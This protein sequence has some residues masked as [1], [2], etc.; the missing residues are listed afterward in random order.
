MGERTGGVWR[1]RRGPGVP[2]DDEAEPGS[3]RRSG[4]AGA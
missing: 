1:G 4:A 2:D 3:G